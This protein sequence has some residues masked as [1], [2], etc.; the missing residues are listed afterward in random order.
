MP[1]VEV[2][3]LPIQM[4]PNIDALVRALSKTDV[5]ETLKKLRTVSSSE[6]A[7][8]QCYGASFDKAPNSDPAYA[9]PLENAHDAADDI[10]STRAYTSFCSSYPATSVAIYQIAPA[11]F[12]PLSGTNLSFYGGQHGQAGFNSENATAAKMEPEEMVVD[13]AASLVVT[14]P[15]D[16]KE[17]RKTIRQKMHRCPICKNRFIEKDIYERHLRDRHPSRFD[18]YMEQQAKVMEEQRLAELEQMRREEIKTGGFILPAREVEE[19]EALADPA[20]IKLPDEE[21]IGGYYTVYDD[22]GMPLRKRRPYRKK[23]SPQCPFCDK[24]FRNDNSLKKHIVKKHPEMVGFV[25]CNKCFKAVKNYSELPNHQ[26]CMAHVC[27]QCTPIRNMITAERLDNHRRKFHRGAQSGFKCN[28]CSRKFL[29]PRKLRKHKKM[30]HIIR[31]P[32]KC[33]FC[34]DYFPT[35]TQ[36][37]LHERIHTGKVKFE[38]NICDYRANR[39]IRLTD[40]KRREHGYV[41]VICGEK[42][43][44]WSELKYHTL[45]VHAGYLSSE[46]QA[47]KMRQK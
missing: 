23:I 29:T 47:G 19:A 31:K 10:D 27:W 26:C 18:V 14:P 9:T 8:A 35:D 38:C 34:D 40:H 39:F 2:P 5:W 45:E 20:E 44:E 4:S 6:N 21:D 25:Q 37:A 30:A 24:R 41:C 43:V 16:P 12:I 11:T 22:Y 15:T 46:S 13:D 7:A 33:Q 3:S 17:M 28:E 32:F 1:P 42:T 36:A